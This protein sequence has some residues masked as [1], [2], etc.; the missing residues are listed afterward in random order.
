[1]KQ[2]I[3]LYI[4][5]AKRWEDRKTSGETTARNIAGPSGE[6]TARQAVRR[7]PAS[8]GTTARNVAKPGKNEM[9]KSNLAQLS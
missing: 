5:W 4:H 6:K 3:S 7:P 1:M 2:G 9:P 8:G